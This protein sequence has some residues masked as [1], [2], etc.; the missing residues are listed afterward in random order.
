MQKKLLKVLLHF[1]QRKLQL[2][3]KKYFTNSLKYLKM[4]K[5]AMLVL[6]G[7]F[8]Q[9]LFS[10]ENIDNELNKLFLDL[11]LET[12]VDNM[13]SKSNLKFEVFQVEDSVTGGTEKTFVANF[14]NNKLIESKIL[15]G[16]CSINKNSQEVK[17][18]KY[19]IDQKIAFKSLDEVIYEYNKLS[20]EY[21]KFGVRV[22][23][24]TE[25]GDDENS[26]YQNKVISI[27]NKSKLITLTFMYPIPTKTKTEYNLYIIC[28]SKKL[29]YK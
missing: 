11:N 15:S 28:Q 13:I 7:L 3:D 26:G 10:Q 1:G 20:A 8:H 18:E 21:E 24:S 27:E 25:E 19:T 22:L 9:F 6:F 16:V 14:N 4:K 12:N 5:I 17:K 23:E 29:W 2:K